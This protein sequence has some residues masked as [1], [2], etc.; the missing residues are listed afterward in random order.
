[1]TSLRQRATRAVALT[2][3]VTIGVFLSGCA[4]YR[5]GALPNSKPAKV[6]LEPIQ[7]E[8]Y[9]SGIISIFQNE[10][11]KMILQS[12]Y[13]ILVE[14]IDAADMSAYIRLTDYTER[15]VAFLES[16]TGQ[17]ISARVTLSAVL[18][19]TASNGEDLLDDDVLTAD[20][21]IYSDPET[22]FPNP[23]DQSKPGI[24]RNLAMKLVLEMELNRPNP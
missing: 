24:A 17:A 20:Y 15:P 19:L 23:S 22:A 6:Y 21:A 2:V 4:G 8:A 12:R 10:L 11:R 9:I 16:D 13:L 18:S 7:N 14:D 5:T 3:W 1:M